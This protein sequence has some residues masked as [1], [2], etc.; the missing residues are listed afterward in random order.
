MTNETKLTFCKNIVEIS[1]YIDRLSEVTAGQSLCILIDRNVLNEYPVFDLSTMGMPEQM[2]IG[3]DLQKPNRK[4]VIQIDVNEKSKTL[5]TCS[6]IIDQMVSKGVT[7]DFVMIGI[8]GGITTDIAGYISTTYMRGMKSL[9]LVPTTVMAQIDA[10]FGG[11]NGVNFKHSSG[12]YAKN[13]IGSFRLPDELVICP[14]IVNTAQKVENYNS[15]SEI[16][17]YWLLSY[18]NNALYEEW[19]FIDRYLHSGDLYANYN[20][21][22]IRACLNVKRWYIGNDITDT[23]GRRIFLNLGHTFAH[24]INS[25]KPE[26]SHGQTLWIALWILY[27]WTILK[28]HSTEFTDTWWSTIMTVKG[29]DPTLNLSQQEFM[30][31]VQHITFDKKNTSD[32]V[33]LI[34]IDHNGKLSIVGNESLEELKT[35]MQYIK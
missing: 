8:G 4:I 9:V 18:A 23:N 10:A 16:L 11:K 3:V 33:R 27:H 32:G 28:G 26:M 17:K 5:E 29:L 7:R 24:A 22:L 34:F 25:F 30:D 35:L 31:V 20:E 15:H 12:D 6:E 21:T 13:L 2:P 1:M 14:Q 19:V